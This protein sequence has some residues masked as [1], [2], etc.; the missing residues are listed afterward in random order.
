MVDVLSLP[1]PIREPNQESA[2]ARG[3][4]HHRG[5]GEKQGGTS[6]HLLLT[7]SLP[8]GLLERLDLCFYTGV[9]MSAGGVVVFRI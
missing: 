5:S 2:H 6:E 9:M 3:V 4:Q 7:A 8:T 1:S